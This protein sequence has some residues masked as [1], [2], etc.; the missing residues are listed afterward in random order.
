MISFI[1]EI[2]TVCEALGA[3]V[4][5]VAAGMG[6][7]A[8]IGPHFL[9]AGLGYGGSCFPKDVKALAYMAAEKGR[10]PQLL[11]AVMEINDDRRKQIIQHHG[12][13]GLSGKTVGYSACLSNPIPMICDTPYH[14]C[15]RAAG[16]R[17]RCG[18]IGRHGVAP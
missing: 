5:E 15:R 16:G 18:S 8:R 1:N 14:H 13:L 3:D 6:Y 11:H 17:P 7:D 2:A 4:K 9:D 10:H 12:M